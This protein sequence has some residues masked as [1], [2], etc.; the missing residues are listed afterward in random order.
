[1]GPV[2][3][4]AL[5]VVEF[6]FAAFEV[7]HGRVGPAGKLDEQAGGLAAKQAGGAGRRGRQVHA[8]GGRG[9]RGRVANFGGDGNDVRHGIGVLRA[10]TN[11][12]EGATVPT[13]STDSVV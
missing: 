2:A 13:C 8:G 5:E 9:H 11:A 10:T 7:D 1:V 4:V 3:P 6:H 12:C